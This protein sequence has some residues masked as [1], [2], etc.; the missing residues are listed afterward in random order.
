L[1]KIG[2]RLIVRSGSSLKVLEDI[3]SEH[4]VKSVTWNRLYDPA[5][6]ERDKALGGTCLLRGCIPT[7]ELLH[8]A[9]TRHRERQT[10]SEG[11]VSPGLLFWLAPAGAW[12][13][14]EGLLPVKLVLRIMFIM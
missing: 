5:I 9:R 14:F 11:F 10:R 7:K 2:S 4:N 1:E 3:I 12:F 8:S 6:I 13:A